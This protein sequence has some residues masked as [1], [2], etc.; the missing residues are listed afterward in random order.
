MMATNQQSTHQSERPTIM[1][2]K[3]S[4]TKS[5]NATPRPQRSALLT[6][7]SPKLLARL[8]EVDKL[9]QRRQWAEAL[10]LLTELD[11]AYPNRIEVVGELGNLAYE[12]NDLH[13]YQT[14]AERFVRL[15]PDN[16]DVLLGLSGAYIANSF[17]WLALT[18]RQRFLQKFPD[19]PKAAEV[20]E[21]LAL[22][23][24]L[25]IDTVSKSNLPEDIALDVLA[26]HDRMR[27]QLQRGDLL[28]VRSTARQLLALAPTFIP[29][30][31]NLSQAEF[32][33]GRDGPGD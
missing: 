10:D 8:E 29:A 26:L 28:G 33:P 16:A 6:P 14:H 15:D 17:P 30:L 4:R 25:L 32:S 2:K 18:T 22:L 27:A 1:A 21:T 24:T 23:K 3:K 7:P 11:R 12:T 19:H 13:A 20:E 5:K 31:N 9:T